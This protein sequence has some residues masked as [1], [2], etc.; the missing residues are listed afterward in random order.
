MFTTYP[1]AEFK[2]PPGFVT[3]AERNWQWVELSAYELILYV[4][5]DIEYEKD[6]TF[7][8]HFLFNNTKDMLSVIAETREICK[9]IEIGLFC[10]RYMNGSASYQ[11]GYVQEIREHKIKH[12]QLFVMA[13][14]SKIYSSSDDVK[15]IPDNELELV[16]SCD[17]IGQ[18]RLSRMNENQNSQIPD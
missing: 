12:K 7:G 2:F 5:L 13:D 8:R 18:G 14:G 3:S 17:Q 10:P 1:H 4:N 15:D 16:I 9:R 11:F 6:D